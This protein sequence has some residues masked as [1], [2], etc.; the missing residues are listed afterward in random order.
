MFELLAHVYPIGI[1]S[2]LEAIKPRTM[3]TSRVRYVAFADDLGG[4]GEL[5]HLRNWWD[6]VVTFDPLL[7][8]IQM[9]RSRIKPIEEE[10]AR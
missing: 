5:M 7:G 6:N 8:F 9:H 2:F 3:D 1:T 4:A 10:K